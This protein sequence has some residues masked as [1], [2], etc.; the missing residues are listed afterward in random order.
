MQYILGEEEKDMTLL[1][2]AAMRIEFRQNISQT[3]SKALVRIVLKAVAERM[4]SNGVTFHQSELGAGLTRRDEKEN[5]QWLG[6][7]E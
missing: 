3:E 1:E 5:H 4:L 2:E 7:E 6:L